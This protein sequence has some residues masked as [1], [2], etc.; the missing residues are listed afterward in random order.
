MLVLR[1]L[2]SGTEDITVFHL[3][4]VRRV[5]NHLGYLRHPH[6]IVK[7]V[8][9]CRPEFIHCPCHHAVSQGDT[10]IIRSILPYRSL[11]MKF[12]QDIGRIPQDFW[13]GSVIFTF[14]DQSSGHCRT[15]LLRGLFLL[16][17]ERFELIFKELKRPVDTVR[18][19][20]QCIKRP[21]GPFMLHAHEICE[22][23]APVLPRL[24]IHT[25]G[26]RDAACSI[27]QRRKSISRI[28]QTISDFPL[29]N[30][31]PSLLVEGLSIP[32]RRHMRRKDFP[33]FHI[34]QTSFHNDPGLLS[35]VARLG[36]VCLEIHVQDDSFIPAAG[37]FPLATTVVL[38]QEVGNV[39]TDFL[40]DLRTAQADLGTAQN[41]FHD[42]LPALQTKDQDSSASRRHHIPSG[43]IRTGLHDI[44][45]QPEVHRVARLHQ[46]LL[47]QRGIFHG[48]KGIDLHVT[49]WG[50]GQGVVYVTVNGPVDGLEGGLCLFLGTEHTRRKKDDRQYDGE[51]SF[52][53]FRILRNKICQRY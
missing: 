8:R 12:L 49:E 30:L 41:L 4:A 7:L 23:E 33:C 13:H 17:H 35:L 43:L 44:T 46:R 36:Y 2:S 25:V 1:E 31:S 10:L 42:D 32:Y 40:P 9:K 5:L 24:G 16:P 39:V 19:H 50:V 45:F 14:Q 6:L 11:H 3:A 22:P 51:K 52:H 48:I 28:I 18:H 38:A 34:G 53:I 37:Q 20:V 29:G 15:T 27:G 21:E 47:T 26:H